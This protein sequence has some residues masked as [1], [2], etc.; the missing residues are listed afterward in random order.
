ME[1]FIPKPS[2]CG[3]LHLQGLLSVEVFLPSLLGLE[4]FIFKAFSAWRSSSSRPSHERRAK[5]LRVLEL[6]GL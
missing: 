2:W 1:I 3:G 5:K 4:A 6:L